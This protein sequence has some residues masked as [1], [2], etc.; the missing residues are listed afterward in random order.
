MQ[1]MKTTLI[2]T[3]AAALAAGTALAQHGDGYGQKQKRGGPDRERPGGGRPA[4]SQMDNRGGE[5]PGGPMSDEMREKMRAE[6]QVIRD[7]AGAIRI[8]TD[9]TRKADLTAQLRTR[10]GDVADRMQKHQEERLAQAAEH[11][12]GLQE[13]IEYAKTHRDELIEEQLQNILSGKGPQRP[14]AFDRFPH[15]KGGPGGPGGRRTPP[16]PPGEGPDDDLPPPPYGEPADD[17]LPP[18]E[19]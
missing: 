6:H 16:P 12:A 9:E 5:R 3:L 11:L 2:L 7:L 18:H 10:L 4:W 14:A 19:D 8:E 13:R 17:L 15:A 1:P